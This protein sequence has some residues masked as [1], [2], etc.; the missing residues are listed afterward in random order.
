M[1][2][3]RETKVCR[4]RE[5]QG[6]ATG[7]SRRVRNGGH[8]EPMAVWVR[9]TELLIFGSQ[10]EAMLEIKTQREPMSGLSPEGPR[11]TSFNWGPEQ[12]RRWS[13]PDPHPLGA[14]EGP[15]PESPATAAAAAA[16]AASA[17]GRQQPLL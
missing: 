12:I 7:R 1:K 15:Q 14:G 2:C 11:R 3:F 17:Q 13:N 6:E 5:K 8:R 9:H 10:K 16:A 4:G